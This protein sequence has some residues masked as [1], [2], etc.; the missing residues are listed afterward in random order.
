MYPGAL[1]GRTI[2]DRFRV[3]R[4]AGQGG[5]GT[6]FLATDLHSGQHVALKLMADLGVGW[7]RFEREVHL[8]AELD[9][10]ALA[11][12]IA[13][14]KLESG[15]PWL[16]MT[17]LEGEDLCHR[18]RRGPLQ[19]SETIDLARR[20]AQALAVIHE[21]GITHRDVKPANLLL[22]DGDPAKVTLVDF[23]VA[24]D[25]L[26]TTQVTGT[27][28]VV[29]TVGYVSPEQARGQRRIDGRA[30]LFSLGCVLYE[31]L[32]GARAFRGS[33]PVAT[34]AKVLVEEVPPVVA[35][36]PA[37]GEELSRIVAHLLAKNAEDRPEDAL[38][39]L[40]SLEALE[41]PRESQGAEQAMSLGAPLRT[42]E[43]RLMTT[44]LMGRH[45]M[46]AEDLTLP[47]ADHDA[48]LE[49][50]RRQVSPFGAEARLLVGGAA[51]ITLEFVG[52]P[53]ELASRA[54]HCALALRAH[55]PNRPIALT[56]GRTDPSSMASIGLSLD[57]G[58]KL[59]EQAEGEPGMA[60]DGVALDEVTMGLL[61]ERFDVQAHGSGWR[62]HGE[63]VTSGSVES[64]PRLLG[65]PL[66]CVG[67]RKEL[68]IL[69]A[70]WEEVVREQVARIIIVQGPAGIGKSRL[71]RELLR[72]LEPGPGVWLLA[73][74]TPLGTSS[75]GAMARD[76]VR[77][78]IGL[79]EGEARE[80]Q[81]QRLRAYVEALGAEDPSQMASFMAK[82]AGLRSPEPPSPTMRAALE[83]PKVLQFWTRRVFVE[84]L[85]LECAR[86]PL[87]LLLEDMHWA[88][89]ASVALLTAAIEELR[90][91]PL[92][93]VGLARPE[94]RG[95]FAPFWLDTRAKTLEL[96]GLPPRAAERLVRAALCPPDGAPAR[97]VSEETIAE[98]V[99]KA[100]GNAFFLEELIRSVAS[101]ERSLPETVYAIAEEHI[102]RT[103][104]EARRALRAASVFGEICWLGG[105]AR[106]LGNVG[107]DQ[108]RILLRELV[109]QELLERR[110]SPRFEGEI[111]YA[112]RH[113]LLR[114]AAYEMLPEAER[115]SAHALAAAW[116]GE[117]EGSHPAMLAEHWGRAGRPSQ[118][119]EALCEAAEEAYFRGDLRTAREHGQRALEL[120]P[121]GKTRGRILFVLAFVHAYAGE[122]AEGGALANEALPF[123]AERSPEWF[124]L[125][126]GTIYASM[127]TGDLMAF[128][129]STMALGDVRGLE[130]SGPASFALMAVA[131]ACIHA[132]GRGVA[133]PY[134]AAL[135]AMD[136]AA[137]AAQP[138]I[139]GWARYVRGVCEG[140]LLDDPCA[141][142]ATQERCAEAFEEAGDPRGLSI[143]HGASALAATLIG[144]EDS[145]ETHALAAAALVRRFDLR[146]S[147]ASVDLCRPFFLIAVDPALAIERFRGPASHG[148]MVFSSLARLGI[149][150]AALKIG[151]LDEVRKQCACLSM[152]VVSLRSARDVLL[153]LV[154]LDEGQPAQAAR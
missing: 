139:R 109:E 31:C 75:A 48:E 8:L 45:Q 5:M 83:D 84:W 137:G 4:H 77:G 99:A 46:R 113:G 13:H 111:E 67:R 23:G 59:L 129:R 61:S 92:L 73:R 33:S 153:G 101:G 125:L 95:R 108:T 68:A 102:A 154:A 144:D 138:V 65:Q 40:A 103:S 2:A 55:Y 9:H 90:D 135:E 42:G 134:I 126:S 52:G 97:L 96:E 152:T 58:A 151:A 80:A 130:P 32:T 38:T 146:V 29:G 27:G 118:E 106:L 117:R 93:V 15:E 100:G 78:P 41:P 62:L 112:F 28:M 79:R 81:W 35:L 142:W 49:A 51:L 85:R 1:E 140:L 145:A 39:L 131:T 124:T 43:Q 133:A 115:R 20:L 148:D 143:A 19:V 44:L 18:L 74:A 71:G 86:A 22:V 88:D 56:T 128:Q 7:R 64:G 120:G 82:L 107:R 147:S 114:D 110:R 69:E 50:L 14:G 21:R 47:A 150:A 30:D 89:A 121:K 54:A 3:E 105:I 63:A 25:A 24:R 17:W 26:S 6:V 60:L 119:L 122:F 72:G 53:A 87:G 136:E 116:L 149:A 132:A 98:I 66:P 37:A 10:P 57:R 36:R 104:P 11:K 94:I 127:S 91:V 12:Y 16:A 34:L 123:F 76:L 70:I 141:S